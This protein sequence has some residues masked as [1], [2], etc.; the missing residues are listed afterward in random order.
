MRSFAS[1]ANKAV[2]TMKKTFELSKNLDRIKLLGRYQILDSGIGC[3][4]SATGI[5]LCADIV[6]A[7]SM[8]VITT[9][10]KDYCDA[11]YFTV[12]IDGVRQE[13]RLEALVGEQTVT[14]AE[15]A[16]RARHTIKIVKQ[17]ESN[18][19]LCTVKSLCF[20]GELLTP[21]PRKEKYIE[22]IGDSLSCGMGALGKKGVENPQTS[23]WED[24][25]QG[26][27][28]GTAEALDA[29]YAIISESGIGLAGSW[30]DPLFDFYSAWSYKRDRAI[31]YDFARAPD[32]ISINLVTND[33]YLNC[34]L[35]ICPIN[36]VKQRAKEF[37]SFVRASYGKDIPIVWVGRFMRLSESYIST[38]D[39]AIAELGGKSAGIYRLDVPTSAGGAQGHPDLAGHAVARDL[40]VQFIK[41]N[42]L[43]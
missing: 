2:D 1:L 13:K 28:Y 6:G 10:E 43:L 37:I 23:R 30:F 18:Y 38:V 11:A 5:E 7:L 29:D 40:L 42:N 15:I 39:E 33:F 41:E 3:D 12:Y 32:L 36:E 31:K 8:T 17:T 25:T 34:D 24:V 19:N 4:H 21:S 22:F 9:R 20:D 26:Y 14:V 35:G 27:T 16:E